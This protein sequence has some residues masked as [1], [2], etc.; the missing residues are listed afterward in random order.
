MASWDGDDYQRR[1]EASASSVDDPHGEANLVVS[2]EPDRVLD[3]GCGT[4]RVAIEL[5]RRGIE[6]VGVDV[7]ASMLAAAR[8]LAPRLRWIQ[9]DL[10]DL[11]LRERFDVVVLAGN[12]PLF[13]RPGTRRGLVNGCARHLADD[14]LLIAGFSLDR[15]YGAD[16]YDADAAA[17]GLQLIER[18]ATWDRDPFGADATYAVS[19]HAAAP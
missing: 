11:D 14:G 18:Y 19:I 8:R 10:V 16:D 5:A 13:T 6:V 7:D 17:A 12:V 9:Q 2:F 3:A 15:G 4:G 1:M